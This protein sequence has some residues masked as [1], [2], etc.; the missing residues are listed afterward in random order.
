M[1]IVTAGQIHAGPLVLHQELSAPG[2]SEKS[3]DFM[4]ARYYS[5]NLG[6]FMSVDPVG[7][8]VG[9][10]QSWNR[11]SYTENNPINGRDPNGL[12][13]IYENKQDRKFFERA[14]ARNSMVRRT[15][16]RFAP[17]SGRDLVIKRVQDAG[18]RHT[19]KE[20]A[21]TTTIDAKYG[22]PGNPEVQAAMVAAYQGEK[23]DE[24]GLAAMDKVQRNMGDVT[25]ATISIGPKA[26]SF[27]KLHELGHVDHATTDLGNYLDAAAE[28]EVMSDSEYEISHSETVA[29][30]YATDAMQ[31]DK[32][33]KQ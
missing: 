19:G 21:A 10:S 8:K 28:A 9:S 16:G 2:P 6:R 23:T 20:V 15:L 22:D 11:Y 26:D 27:D 7:G 24:A 32:V 4:H 30:N 1:A 5:P 3:T 33:Q 18:Q 29:D 12:D 25:K 14:A 17:G 13:V 31:K